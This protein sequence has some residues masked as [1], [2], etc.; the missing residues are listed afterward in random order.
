MPSRQQS[1]S[2]YSLVTSQSRVLTVLCYLK[3][4][5][6]FSMI[7]VGVQYARARALSHSPFF[8]SVIALLCDLF[9]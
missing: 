7:G 3:S 9:V 6:Y 4:A 5:L 2:W 1:K 8:F